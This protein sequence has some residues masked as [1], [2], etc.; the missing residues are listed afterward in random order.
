MLHQTGRKHGKTETRS[1]SHAS[2][3]VVHVPTAEIEVTVVSVRISVTVVWTWPCILCTSGSA[4][5]QMTR[6][7]PM[8]DLDH[9]P[10]K[11]NVEP[12]KT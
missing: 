6:N 10:E 1:C 9:M 5:I 3:Q 7:S 2:T 4:S 11:R 8:K 12:K